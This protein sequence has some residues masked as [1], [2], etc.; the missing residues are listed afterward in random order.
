MPFGRYRGLA[1]RDLPDDYLGW[2]HSLDNLHGRLRNAV[3]TEWQ[4]RQWEAESRRPVEYAPE[5]DGEDRMPFWRA[6]A[7][8]RMSA[9]WCA[10]ITPTLAA[11][12]TQW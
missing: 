8:R 5:L 4:Y 1:V 11:R 3:Q 9:S 10:N 2:L 12:P 6:T 7:T